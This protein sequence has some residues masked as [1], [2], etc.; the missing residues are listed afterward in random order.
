[1]Y[2]IDDFSFMSFT[3][4]VVQFTTVSSSSVEGSG[5]ATAQLSAIGAREIDVI[6][7]YVLCTSFRIAFKLL[8]TGTHSK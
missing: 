1:M 5:V 8:K 2:Y 6:V 4:V 7:R 3:D